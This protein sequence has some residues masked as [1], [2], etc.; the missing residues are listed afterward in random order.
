MKI[1]TSTMTSS[2]DQY[3]EYRR[4]LGYHIKTDAYLLR[5]FGQYADQVASGKP[6]TTQLALQWATLP[7]NCKRVY[8]A[9]RL[10]AVRSLSRYLAVFDARTEIPMAG[11]LGRSFERV[12]PHIYTPREV[13]ALIQVS[14]TYQPS[15]RRDPS[16]GQRNAT[17]IGTL[18]C[19]GMRIGEVL[20]MTDEDVDLKCGVITVNQSKNLPMR[21]V[22]ISDSAVEQLQR[23][24]RA[25]DKRYG[26]T[27]PTEPF[28]RSPRGGCLTYSTMKWSFAKLCERA[29]L[30]AASNRRPRLHDFRHTFACNHLLRAYRENRNIDNA[31][32]ELSVYLGHAT[33]ASTYWY[34]TAV[35]ALMEQCTK[36]SEL[37][38]RRS[39][40]GGSA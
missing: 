33:L 13:S 8:H 2:V 18:A 19:T 22:P 7:N 25:R 31:V 17:V 29:D 16:T 12:S 10:D 21:L 11:L 26:F 14:L 23:Y 5:S 38:N 15:L 3:I 37:V 24:R 34:L 6:L 9:K 32:H 36:R 35:P 1:R 4:S 27:K 30:R 40:K 39:R 28:I 20:S